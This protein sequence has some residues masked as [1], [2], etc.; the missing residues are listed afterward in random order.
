MRVEVDSSKVKMRLDVV[1]PQVHVLADVGDLG[2]VLQGQEI[3]ARLLSTW[4]APE[5]V[6]VRLKTPGEAVVLAFNDVSL[7]LPAF[8]AARFGGGEVELLIWADEPS[9]NRMCASAR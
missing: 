6:Q 3:A 2:E 4:F 1:P 8:A 9:G 5:I 7:A